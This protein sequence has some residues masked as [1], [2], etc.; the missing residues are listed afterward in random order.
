MLAKGDF[1]DLCN[2]PD[3]QKENARIEDECGG[4]IEAGIHMRGYVERLKT[5]SPEDHKRIKQQAKMLSILFPELRKWI[6]SWNL[7][8]GFEEAHNIARR[9][10]MN[11]WKTFAEEN[12]EWVRELLDE[13]KEIDRAEEKSIRQQTRAKLAE[14]FTDEDWQNIANGA[15]Q[16]VKQNILQVG[17][18]ELAESATVS[19]A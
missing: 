19:A 2:D 5:L 12:A 16:A 18:I 4:Y 6:E 1:S 9:I 15:A 8:A 14:M 7:G 13:D 11:Q 3:W 17:E 10:L